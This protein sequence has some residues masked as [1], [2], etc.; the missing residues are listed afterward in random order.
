MKDIRVKNNLDTTIN[1]EQY[2]ETGDKI[3]VQKSLYDFLP[4]DRVVTIDNNGYV[5]LYD[6]CIKISDD[7][8][9]EVL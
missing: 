9:E 1:I 7:M 4:I 3:I 2:T 8:I 5:Y 6:Q